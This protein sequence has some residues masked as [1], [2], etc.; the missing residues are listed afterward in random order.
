MSNIKIT[1]YICEITNTLATRVTLYSRPIHV[2]V[3]PV[4]IIAPDPPLDLPKTFVINQNY[5]NPFNP[6]TTI[7]YGLTQK[8]LVTLKVFDTLGREVAWLVN[9]NQIAGY[10]QITWNAAEYPSG[11]Y[12]YK[13]KAGDF[14]AIRKMILIK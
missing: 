2:H 1:N 4:G 8:T 13:I 6:I 7:K 3:L 10:Y 9:G 14:E 5:P 12:F 11:I